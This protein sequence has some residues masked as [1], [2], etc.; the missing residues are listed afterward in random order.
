MKGNICRKIVILMLI[1]ALTVL[2][3]FMIS[4]QIVHA[5]EMNEYDAKIAIEGAL[6]KYINY[7]ISDQDKGTLVQ[8]NLR[9][10]IEYGEIENYY[11]IKESEISINLNQIDNKYPFNVKVIA[12]S[13][14]ATNGK[15][16]D[17]QE[18]YQYDK[19]TGSLKIKVSNQDENGNIIYNSKQDNE[20]RDEYL[21]MC[22]Y[23]T[24]TQ[25]KIE[26]DISF[27]ASVKT[28]LFTDGN[29]EIVNNGKFETKVT[30]D[31]GSLTSINSKTDDI[32][33]GNIK[34]NILNGTQ[35]DTQYKEKKEIVVS[36]K[37]AQQKIEVSE[38]NLFIRE[39]ENNDGEKI[40]Q[41]LGNDGELVYK[42]TRIGKE[43]IQKVFGEKGKIEILNGDGDI[44]Y[45]ID[46]NTQF[47]DS[48]FVTVNYEEGVQSLVIKTSDVTNEGILTIENIK[49][50]KYTMNDL[51]NV[52]IKTLNQIVGI[53]E[54]IVESQE[55][56]E[57]IQINEKEVS[58]VS[59]ENIIDIKEA[60]TN[61]TFD[62]NNT[63]WSNK[64]QNQIEFNV[65][66]DSSTLKYNMFN[67]PSFKIEL[68]SQVEKVI[69]GNSS[70]VYG[71]GLELKDTYV[72]TE[73]DGN[74]SIVLN[75]SGKQTK[76]D[77]N[78]LGLKTNIN[79]SA[80]IILKKDINNTSEKLNLVY[81]N[82]YVLNNNVD[83]G[84]IE[85]QIQI[86][87]YQNEADEVVEEQK[88]QYTNS[89]NIQEKIEGLNVKVS[90]T[91]GEDNLKD[92]DIVYEGEYIKYN[93]K[94]TNTS[95]ETINDVKVVGS[96]PDGLTY[97]EL[98]ADYYNYNGKYQY[99]FDKSL[100]EKI[101]DVGTLEAGK[102]Y[103]TFYEV[104]VNDLDIGED[105]REI[106]SNISSY[107]GDTK[108]TNYE[109]KNIIKQAKAKIFVD[110]KL[111]NG[112]NRW[113]YG[114]HLTGE[115][116]KQVTVV[117]KL[118][119]EFEIRWLG[120]NKKLQ[121]IPN[122]NITV[123]EDNVVTATLNVDNGEPF[124]FEGI[125]D[126]SEIDKN[127]DESFK[128][129]IA[130]ATLK[131]GDNEY[132]S[133]ET[134]IKFEYSNASISMTSPN[135]GQEVNYGEEIEYDIT[136][137][138]TGGANSTQ[139]DRNSISVEL[140]DFL[141][142]DL[143]PISVEYENWE[144]VETP[145]DEDEGTSVTNGDFIKVSNKVDISN[146]IEDENG[147]KLPNVNIVITVPEEEEAHIIIKTKAGFV[148]EK[149]TIENTATITSNLIEV[150]ED[151]VST[152]TPILTKTSNVVSHIILPAIDTEPE[153]PDTP[154]D[155]ED[156]DNPTDPED[157]NNPNNPSESGYTISGVAWLDDNE[158]GQ[159]QS[160]EQLLNGITVM[161][162]NM[163]NSGVVA[164]RTE[165]N[166]NGLY[167][168]TG[169]NEGQYIVIFQYNTG[170]YY[171]TDYQKSGVSTSLNS[172]VTDQEITLNGERIQAAVT[173]VITLSNSVSNIDIGLIENK[174]FDL[175]LDKV[176]S[177]VTVQTNK[178]TTV[179]SY[180]NQKLAKVD[181]R[182][183][184]IEGANVTVEYKITVTNE[185]ELA[186]NVGSISDYLPDGF[187]LTE[188]SAQNWM[189]QKN[190]EVVNIS[191]ANRN[192]NG[193]ESVTLTLVATK[194]MTSDSTGTFT[195]EAEI[196]EAT[197][198]KKIA[199]IDSI[200]GNRVN[201]EDDFSKA[202]LIISIGT[203]IAVYI[204]IGIILAVLV[205]IVI[206]VVI[207]KGKLKIGKISKLSIFVVMFVAMTILQ[208]I[209][210]FAG[211]YV[212]DQTTFTFDSDTYY[213][214]GGT[215]SRFYGGPFGIGYCM[216]YGTPNQD[217]DST[218]YWHTLYNLAYEGATLK[219]EE[220]ISSSSINLQKGNEEVN[221][222]KIDN[223]NYLLGPFIVT[224][225][226]NNG[227]TVEARDRNNNVIEGAV[228][229][230]SNG[231]P[232]TIVGNATFYVKIPIQNCKNGISRI[233]LTNS[234]T[235]ATT[236]E[237]KYYIIA[238]YSP[239]TILDSQWVTT[240]GYITKQSSST[241]VKSAYVEWTDIRAGGLEIIKQ[242]AD[243]GDIKLAG[244]PVRITCE[245]T[246][247]NGIYTT[248]SNGRIYI[249]NL[250]PGLYTVT[251]I[252]NGNYGYSVIESDEIRMYSGASRTFL[253]INKKQTGNL[254]I[255]KKDSD[256]G[257]VLSGVEFKIRDSSGKYIIAVNESGA[258]QSR[259]TGKIYLGNM[260]TTTNIDS[261]TTFI[262][263]SNGVIE[264]YNMLV[265]D[266]YVS[267]T[268]VGDNNPDYSGEADS[269]SWSSNAGSGSGNNMKVTVERQ[270][271]Y[272]TS[273]TSTIV[274]DSKK[275]I[276]DG[277]Y[278]IQTGV[279]SNM[280]IDLYG[281]Y[282]FR[283]T[284]IEIYQR[285]KG[286]AQRYYVEYLGNGYY[287]L[288]SIAVNSL[289]DVKD[290]GNTPGTNV[291]ICEENGNTAQHWL[292][293]S[294]GNGYYYII[295]RSNG[296]YLDVDGGKT[297]NGTNVQVYSATGGSRQKFK[298]NDLTNVSNNSVNVLTVNNRKKF[299]KLS[300]YVWED[301]AWDIGKEY[302]ANELYQ[303]EKDD[304]NDKLMQNVT[305]RLRDKNN[306]LV[307]FKDVNG[308]TVTEVKTDA[309]GKY[310]MSEI[311]INKLNEYYIEFSYN[312]M[313]YESVNINN[314]NNDNGTRAI[315]GSN[316][317]TYNEKFAEITYQQNGNNRYS[318]Q[319]NNSNGDKINDLKYNQGDYTSSIDYEGNLLY[320]YSESND[321]SEGQM[322]EY[323]AY[324]VNGVADKYIISSTTRD[325]Y[326]SVGKTGYLSDI[327]TADQIIS[328][329]I[330][331]I[332][333]INLGLKKRERPDLSVVKDIKSSR[334]SINNETH[335]Y[336]YNDRFTNQAVYG[337]G[338]NMEDLENKFGIKY[339]EKYGTMSYTRALYA[340]DIKYGGSEKLE[341]T[342]T[343]KI[344]VRNNATTINA[345]IYELQD[346]FDQKYEL[347]NVGLDI[348]DDG[349]IKENSIISGI[350]ANTYAGNDQYQKMTIKYTNGQP[351]L[352][353]KPETE[354]C[355]YVELRVRPENLIDIVDVG[356]TVKLD[357]IT[358]I[359]SYG[360][361]KTLSTDNDGNIT[362]EEVYAGI[363]KDSQ[364]GNLNIDDKTTWEDDTDRAPGLLL[365][366]QEARNVSGQ[367]FLDST[368]DLSSGEVR[369][370][371]GQLDDGEVGIENV[372]VKLVNPS[373]GNAIEVW[374]EEGWVEA[375]T[376]TDENG[377]YTLAGF[378][379]G[380]YNIEYTWGDKTYKVQNYKST[381][382]DEEVWRAKNSDN[383]W[384]KDEF[385]QNYS[386]EWTNGQEI[387]TSDA[388]DN[389]DTRLE[390]DDQITTIT[391]A[392]KEKI[393][394]AYEEGNDLITKMT[395][396]TP[397][398]KVNLEYN[399]D[400]TNV[401]DEYETDENG[402]L[403]V[404][405]NGQIIPKDSFKNNIRNIDFG[406][407][408]R[409]RQV[410]SLDKHV[411]TAKITLAD[412]NILVNA[413]L[414][415]NG[416]L[417]DATQY[418]TVIPKS[419]VNGQVKI[420]LD[421]EIIQGASLEIKYNLKITNIS[422][423]EYQTEDF[424][425][426][427]SGH[428]ED[429]SK[430]VTLQ[431]ALIIDYLDN[432]MVTDVGDGSDWDIVESSNRN[433][434]LI[435]SGLLSDSLKNTL[436]SSIKVVTTDELKD[437][438]LKPIGGENDVSINI[439]IE[440]YK[441]LSS[442]DDEIFS[443]NNAE[444]ITVIKNNGGSTLITTPGNYVPNDSSTSEE[445]SSTSES[446]VVIPPTG[447]E[448][449]YI[450]YIMLAISSLG[451][452]ISGIILIKKFVLGKNK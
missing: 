25:E 378:I 41:N 424:Y 116:G 169:L 30:E 202:E 351:I 151:G 174:V 226:N 80:T 28:V 173:D 367:V 236:V 119:E 139:Q 321:F 292:I 211:D 14:Q 88:I 149:T 78:S 325:A 391:N 408:E 140:K 69:L 92:N 53:N 264:V 256:T 63:Q 276:E 48:G 44:L 87:S 280:V 248:D 401:R 137:K 189:K 81:D 307:K 52:K 155:P 432:T 267:E 357:N 18:D 97:G 224:C 195:N 237:R 445:D 186:A 259:V 217:V 67:N 6:G 16:Q 442:G 135:E 379:P 311:P 297:S 433:K 47:D 316:R 32:Y 386:S 384:Y 404:D 368:G 278:E 293:R 265:G 319:S 290:A 113:N 294:A 336:E 345:K 343:Y 380:E 394:E 251:E 300:G 399:N 46:E 90:P 165:T 270:R 392:E 245:A 275:T 74:L 177:K 364:P 214:S 320:G 353:L 50:I 254:K 212:P 342:V 257:K 143:E 411:K 305:V 99:N 138:N 363:D 216:N 107:V 153:Y 150:D 262:T 129:L 123:S 83:H 227:Y 243:N 361:T 156:P 118:P 136:I 45:T 194:K 375:I 377:Q 66:L 219:K 360:S 302:Y 289:I 33:N 385:K 61:I 22:Y 198:V 395:S 277:L 100:K 387:R 286:I 365:V 71:N 200:P 234:M 105:Q 208:N 106:L 109:I 421:Q 93:V 183:K 409:A 171:I 65:Y 438:V 115:Q 176:I 197:N 220:E 127:T 436:S 451:I 56:E 356:Q 288:R 439:G 146:D 130:N 334:V 154:V 167:S 331:E 447:L 24:Y 269:I 42:S 51:Q 131:V 273:S 161:L 425:M 440:G 20:V 402:V 397:T 19:N 383:Q 72:E 196:G 108:V 346:Y 419:I 37:E 29:K 450:S 55:D 406:L 89:T 340:S 213:A 64:S 114:V 285:N 238:H 282:P 209:N 13:T 335:I 38:D 168:F 4:K 441:L 415:D 298:F 389:Y 166:S 85:K 239:A 266:Y 11:P 122:D 435:E 58:E 232:T 341:V 299:I 249:E 296:L 132:K 271:S 91:R 242:D 128:M 15:T 279:S 5:Q 103:E 210:S 308:N 309:N 31:I 250:E 253:L 144:Q 163:Q 429:E 111:D 230:N 134:R 190:G 414:D 366:L 284:N 443:E 142:E 295:S 147:N 372:E 405:E 431:P 274:K 159:R 315:E 182:S 21:I 306:N 347:I 121:E 207:R 160:S 228:I 310:V 201:S 26:R 337:D 95:N 170:V 10:G 339:Q 17:I 388:V 412:G 145:V 178:Q 133:N 77:E 426:Y 332:E 324:P 36:K 374:T 420:E 348:N 141:P 49:E 400:I 330:D 338:Y 96:I 222:K 43:N 291:Q 104:Q 304:K 179:Y 261:A 417:V 120:Y 255:E 327:K 62:I 376:R 187:E 158:D 393:E 34:S 312:G 231:T 79:L 329:G 70:I 148:Y 258:N 398:F 430:I 124:L 84:N 370:G 326:L 23:D 246:G 40:T 240:T 218:D 272:N 247:F 233:R 215:I 117:L 362:K 349:S 27:E 323:L 369:Q 110:A 235:V 313:A 333:N 416:N 434:E 184:E 446:V 39:Y 94:V 102:S 268:Y 283:E 60:Q 8:Y 407:V 371:N 410:L 281:S 449:D 35:Y 448:V 260:K 204:S 428:G 373:T 9:T 205:G 418:V 206:F 355:V 192:I 444:I 203:G 75:L 244:V 3:I 221:M 287:T 322:Q 59:V 437:I 112:E 125:M 390:I 2:D 381:V 191:M 12:K 157:P 423:V 422:E 229:A 359:T 193:G 252:S 354:G 382:V 344:G 358:E 76:Y 57:D 7:D 82:Y 126:A 68:P 225:D 403:I 396:T 318:G 352:S 223:S 86:E 54:E 427:G 241:G 98:E 328:E 185:G 303:G 181:I 188:E 172:D 164:G 301:I 180:D 263:D 162:V 1:C 199:D 413:V 452:L 314:I 175:K 101:I 73:K 350:T 317:T 152:I